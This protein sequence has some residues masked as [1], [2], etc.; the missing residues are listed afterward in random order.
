MRN[1]VG[2]YRTSIGKKIL[3]AGTG[4]LLFLFVLVHMIG[5]LKIYQGPEKFNAYAEFLRE[6]GYPALGH[7]QLL[8][9]FRIV[10]L[11]A[12]GVHFV[13]ALQLWLQSRR[14]RPV[15][16]RQFE[17]QSFSYASRTMRWGGV[18]IGAFVVYHLL[19]LTTGTVHPEFEPGS[20]YRNVV[21]GF[22]AWPVSLAYV[23]AMLPLGLHIYHGLWSG[24]Q[25]LAVQNPR[26]LLFRRAV[27]AT[28][29]GLIV[30]GNISIPLSILAGLV[31]LPSS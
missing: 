6:A 8:W 9:I 19:H 24:T 17:D 14:A 2:L 1:A 3:M 7:G 27:A 23:L 18:I 31:K 25:T 22:S 15:G 13:S 4:I 16:Y 30:V 5:N 20:V 12:V 21:S 28:V 11:A 29:A 10:L 26:I